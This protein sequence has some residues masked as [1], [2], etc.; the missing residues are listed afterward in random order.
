MYV[1]KQYKQRLAS[2]V[3]YSMLTN[4]DKGRWIFLSARSWQ[5][6]VQ[7]NAYQHDPGTLTERG[8]L[9]ITDKCPDFR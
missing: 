3:Q 1:S 4:T 8:T 5:S 7:Y 9:A 2:K 6:R